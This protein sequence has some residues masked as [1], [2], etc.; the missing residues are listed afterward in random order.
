MEVKYI[1]HTREE[2]G[3]K[4]EQPLISHLEGTADLAKEF[5]RV[6]GSG[7]LAY[8]CGLLHDLGKY[9]GEFQ[10]RIKNDGPKC[11]H[12]TAGARILIQENQGYGDLLG[13]IIMG[14]HS[15][16]FDYG[17]RSDIGEEGTFIAQLNKS[18]P[19][20]EQYNVGTM[21]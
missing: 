14:H 20:F 1:A 12:S 11:D 16:L 13:Y 18:I 8:I 21:Q 17:S 15:G 3:I 2:N 19:N 5:A 7:Q 6:F 4:A 9:S 10:N